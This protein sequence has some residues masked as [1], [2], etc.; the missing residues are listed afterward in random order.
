[1]Q[2]FFKLFHK[3]IM[4]ITHETNEYGERVLVKTYPNGTVTKELDRPAPAP[5]LPKHISVGRFFDRFSAQ[6]YPILAS[7]NPMV[8]ALIKDC[9]VRSYIDLDDPQL[10]YG[11]QMLV[12]AGFA[13]DV[14][15]ILTA[16]LTDIERA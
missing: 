11:L 12:D 16:P 9:S 6:K 8:Q 13:I 3:L 7:S 5:S 2:C 10:P 4:V 14:Q 15:A 1:M